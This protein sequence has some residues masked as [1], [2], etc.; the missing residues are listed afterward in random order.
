MAVLEE[1]VC[2][3]ENGRGAVACASGHAAQFLA[4]V[5]LLETGDEFIASKHLYGGSVTQ[6]GI[7]FKKLGWTCHFVDMREP[8]SIRAAMTNKVKF[9][10]CEPL[11]NPG[12]PRAPRVTASPLWWTGI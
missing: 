5:S 6:F 12:G 3:L 11:A 1:R 8:D 7:S 10:F 9:I 2:G 4:A